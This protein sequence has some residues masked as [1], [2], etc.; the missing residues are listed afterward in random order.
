MGSFQLVETI[1]GGAPNTRLSY[2]VETH[3]AYIV[4]FDVSQT[5]QALGFGDSSGKTIFLR[6]FLL[7]QARNSLLL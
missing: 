3:G 4:A 1:T 6:P 5:Y 7:D 2:P